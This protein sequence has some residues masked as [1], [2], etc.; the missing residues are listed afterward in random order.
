MNSFEFRQGLFPSRLAIL[1]LPPWVWSSQLTAVTGSGTCENPSVTAVQVTT[2]T[3][4]KNAIACANENTGRMY[5]LKLGDD[6]R[7]DEVWEFD[8]LDQGSP[9]SASGL[10]LNSSA[11]VLIDGKRAGG[12]T[13]KLERSQSAGEFRLIYVSE[14]AVLAIENLELRDGKRPTS[15]DNANHVGH[16]LPCFFSLLTSFPCPFGFVHHL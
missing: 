16:G 7:F 1:L 14:G 9:K 13:W 8:N 6:I 5:S 15:N 12:G 2:P 4:M 3:A 11:S 10:W